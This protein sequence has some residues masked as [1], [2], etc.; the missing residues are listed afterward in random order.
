M[1]PLFPS[2]LLFFNNGRP[3]QEPERT[4]CVSLLASSLPGW[5]TPLKQWQ[6][7]FNTCLPVGPTVGNVHS[8][9]LFS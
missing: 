9:G 6:E 8:G 1:A 5:F 4:A 2:F 3:Q 7:P